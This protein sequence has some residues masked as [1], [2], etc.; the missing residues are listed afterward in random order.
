MGPP[1]THK[2]SM[3][4]ARAVEWLGVCAST[5]GG[6]ISQALT[7]KARETLLVVGTLHVRRG[8]GVGAL[9]RPVA[10]RELGPTR[11]PLAEVSRQAQ[12]RDR[13]S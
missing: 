8:A 11:P 6:R 5:E 3:E 2:R 4:N 1:H 13:Q 9:S 7:R 10:Q 12:A